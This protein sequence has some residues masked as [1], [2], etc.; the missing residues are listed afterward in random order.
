MNTVAI[1]AI[2][3]GLIVLIVVLVLI[4]AAIIAM[5]V[6]GKKAQKKQA[7]QQELMEANKQTVS[8]LII[9][10]KRMKIKESGLPQSVIDQTPKLMRN[11]KLPVMRRS[12]TAF[13]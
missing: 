10:K 1:L 7:E 5:Y 13:L 8:M 4:L 12:S 11:Q 2:K 6:L 3:P 9:D